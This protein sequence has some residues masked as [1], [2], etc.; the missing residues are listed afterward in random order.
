M[1]AARIGKLFNID[2]I[3][4]LDANDITWKIRIASANIIAEDRKREAA[5][6]NKPK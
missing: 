6:A 5:A 3:I 2:P 4:V 1:T